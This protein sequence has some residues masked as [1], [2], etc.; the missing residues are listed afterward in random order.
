MK[1][2]LVILTGGT[3]VSTD[4]GNGLEPNSDNFIKKYT[5]QWEC[6]IDFICPLNIDSSQITPK[7]WVMIG[8]LIDD[9]HG[10]YSG[11]LITHGTDTMAYTSTAL[12]LMFKNLDIPV[13]LTGS[14]IP[15][16]E[17]SSDAPSN[18]D[19]AR[20]ILL[21]SQLKGVFVAFAGK[22]MHGD[23]CSKVQSDDLEAFQSI[24]CEDV[25]LDS[26]TQINGDYEFGYT[27]HSDHVFLLKAF[28]G[29]GG[30]L[31]R[32]LHEIGYSRFVIEAYGKGSMPEGFAPEV[33]NII[34]T[35]G[36][37]GIVSQCRYNGS[38]CYKY[39][40]GRDMIDAGAFDYGSRTTEYAV[41]HMM[42]C[43]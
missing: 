5:D 34:C 14:Q 31:L 10:K 24:N 21:N 7:D 8:R 25:S 16:N 27:L 2:V 35:G 26:V 9:N 11:I 4:S 20:K 23:S 37:V 39:K 6:D 43:N 3:I 33:K 28:P 15:L 32:E 36:K 42:L 17:V 40:A 1:N 30:G 12:S 41:A 29:V 18:L 38:E 19:L 22:V 13:V